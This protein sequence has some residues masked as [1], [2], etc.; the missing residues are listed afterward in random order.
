MQATGY[1]KV[2]IPRSIMAVGGGGS[3]FVSKPCNIRLKQDTEQ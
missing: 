1:P 3:P 2:P